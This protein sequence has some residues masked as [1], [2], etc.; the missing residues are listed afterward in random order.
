MSVEPRPQPAS[1]P[2]YRAQRSFGSLDGVRCLCILPVLWHHAGVSS[3]LRLLGRGFL[4]VDMFFVLSGF[5]IVTLLLRERD[6]TGGVSLRRFYAR[7]TLRIFP[8]YYGLLLALAVAYGLLRT[9]EE[10]DPFFG[11]LPVYLLYVSNW[12]TLQAPNLAIMWSLATEEQFYLVWP[13][14]EKW[15]R[16]SWIPAVLAAWLALNQAI[17]FGWLDSVFAG[18]YGTPTVPDLSI[19][20]TTF[21]PICL[22]VILAHLLH[23]RRWFDRLA[24]LLQGR[25]MAPLLLGSLVLEAQ[26]TP[27]DLSGWPRLL[28]HLTMAAWLGS[29]VVREDH[30]LAG[31][32]RLRPIA[33]IGAISYGMYLYHLWVFHVARL[34]NEQLGLDFLAALFVTGGLLTIL[35]AELSFRFLETPFLGWKR[36]FE[37]GGAAPA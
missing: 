4:G 25:L 23:E 7:R 21:T 30:A 19:L 24:P 20:D 1:H 8:P 15:I 29:L 35:V 5:L 3:D 12:S 10:G 11:A 37:S 17:N 6:R 22:G 18:L 32:L 9:A 34:A 33:R 28:V 13:A 2:A 36:R 14:C 31:L 16:R 27:A 26:L